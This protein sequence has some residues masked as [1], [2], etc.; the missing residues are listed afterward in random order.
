MELAIRDT[1]R[2]SEEQKNTDD[3]IIIDVQESFDF[4][5]NLAKSHYENFPVASILVPKEKRKH[6]AAIYAFSRIADD[7]ADE[8][9]FE[10]LRMA[11]L[12][13][14]ENRLKKMEAGTPD[15][16]VF[17]ALRE[18]SHQFQI[19]TS[20]YYDLLTAFK[21]DVIV[22]RYQTF[23]QLL[24]Y[25][26]YSANP[27]GR[28][29][30]HVMDYKVPKFFEYSD[31]ICTALQLAN[32]WQDISIDIKKNR[33]YLPKEDLLAFEYT[34]DNLLQSEFNDNFKR[35]IFFQIERTQDLFNKG[36]PLCENL[37]GR[38]GLELKLTWLGGTSI[39]NKIRQGRGDVF[40]KRPQLTKLDFITLLFR[41]LN[42]SHWSE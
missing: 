38:F 25:C 40:S 20:L 6:I 35:L 27:V 4:C 9:E 21:M 41:C 1:I 11:K 18:T 30:L 8:E 16:P 5:L 29:V 19:P 3:K 26:R 42:F 12:K 7:Y 28:L 24:N 15:H 13:D 14:W 2:E 33:I 32:F 22:S 36:K 37:S 39:L 17:V 10:G 31:F 23:D 34:E